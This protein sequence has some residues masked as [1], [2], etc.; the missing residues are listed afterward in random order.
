M[1]PITETL[2]RLA[3]VI[4]HY[5]M[6]HFYGF[7]K[8][9]GI[10]MANLGAL[11]KLHHGGTSGVSFLGNELGI[12]NAA[13]SQ[14]LDKLVQLGLVQRKEDPNDRRAK[15][16]ELTKKGT[17]LVQQ[18]LES[19]ETF[20]DDLANSFTDAEQKDINRVLEI[21]SD[22]VEQIQNSSKK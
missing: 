8:E 12:S 22:R 10:T 11:M 13:A 17:D 19:R 1:K 6:D 21:L 4:M 20:L 3:F 9:N 15:L 5:N 7:A 18:C 2:K 14:M 16:L